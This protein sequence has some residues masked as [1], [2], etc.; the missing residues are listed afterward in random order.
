MF[1]W[2]S[3]I[4]GLSLTGIAFHL[5]DWSTSFSF[6]VFLSVFSFVSLPPLSPL[7]SFAHSNRPFKSEMKARHSLMRITS[8]SSSSFDIP[9]GRRCENKFRSPRENSRESSI[10][11]EKRKDWFLESINSFSS[12]AYIFRKKIE[13]CKISI[14]VRSRRKKNNFERKNY[15]NNFE[16]RKNNW[17][18]R[19]H[20]SSPFSFLPFLERRNIFR[21]YIESWGIELVPFNHIAEILFGQ[22]L[23]GKEMTFSRTRINRRKWSAESSFAGK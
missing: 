8:V 7:P 20:S 14:L 1:P 16:K 18:S 9:A 6:S 2:E 21:I 13:A 5:D 22:I 12:R 17:K 15:R 4:Y 3:I 10:V 23:W 19:I 11:R